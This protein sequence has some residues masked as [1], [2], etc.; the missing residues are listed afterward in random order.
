LYTTICGSAGIAAI[1]ARHGVVQDSEARVAQLVA[2][3]DHCNRLL[4]ELGVGEQQQAALAG[5]GI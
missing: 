5:A 4:A 1:E 3:R 2:L